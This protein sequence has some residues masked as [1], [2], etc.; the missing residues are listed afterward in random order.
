MLSSHE[1]DVKDKSVT[2]IA[3]RTRQNNTRA[4]FLM[5]GAAIILDGFRCDRL[6]PIL[7]HL[8]S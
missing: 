3:C 8:S 4:V 1:D 7:E 5:I 2:I 6:C